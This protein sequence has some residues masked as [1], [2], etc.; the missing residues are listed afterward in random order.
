VDR[1]QAGT[2]EAIV[3]SMASFVAVPFAERERKKLRKKS[4]NNNNKIKIKSKISVDRGPIALNQ[5]WIKVQAPTEMY[6]SP[7]QKYW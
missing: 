3:N 5:R 4:K 1:Y 6:L 2:W 7:E